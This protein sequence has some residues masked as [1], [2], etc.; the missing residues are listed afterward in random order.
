MIPSCSVLCS[1]LATPNPSDERET[2]PSNVEKTS[3]LNPPGN[4]RSSLE[5]PRNSVLYVQFI[6][7]PK[8]RNNIC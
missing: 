1:D 6:N 8:K 2:L 5:I 3:T 4:D 7:W